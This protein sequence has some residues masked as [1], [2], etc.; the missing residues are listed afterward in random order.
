MFL[1]IDNYDSFVYNLV[2]YFKEIGE[3]IKIVRKDKITIEEIRHI[4]PEGIVISPGPKSPK[5]STECLEIIHTF[6][7]EIPILGVCLGHQ[8]IG[9]YFGAKVIKGEKPIH[10]KISKIKHDGKGLFFSI[11]KEFNVTRYHSLIVDENT[12]KEPLIITARS[13][14]NVIMGL[15]HKEY[16]IESVQFHPEA[17]L[18]EYGHLILKNFVRMCRGEI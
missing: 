18:T 16:K 10:G 7:S 15:R 13:E 12:V 5:E 4:N 17:E 11:E 6:K 9:S 2:R 1:M 8:C 3:E 14:D